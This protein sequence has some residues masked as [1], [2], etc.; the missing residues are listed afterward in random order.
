MTIINNILIIFICIDCIG[1][2]KQLEGY[3]SWLNKEALLK[4]YKAIITS[5][6]QVDIISNQLEF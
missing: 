5:H 4:I 2:V 6:Y 1:A 3:I